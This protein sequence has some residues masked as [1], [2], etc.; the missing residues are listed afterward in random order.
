MALLFCDSFNHVEDGYELLKWDAYYGA[1]YIEY[2]ST[3]GRQGDYGM[4]TSG[5]TSAY[6]QKTLSSNKTT[7]ITGFA[8]KYTSGSSVNQ[9]LMFLEGASAQF[10]V[11]VDINGAIH[12]YKGSSVLLGSSS[13][14]VVSANTW[15]YFEIKI[16]FS[17]TVGTVE[18]KIDGTQVIN[19]TGIDTC[20]TANAYCTAVQLYG[21]GSYCYFD[22]F[23][24]CDTLG[25]N[26]NDFLGDVEITPLYPTSDV[27]NDFTPSAGV[28]HYAL[29]DDPQ[30]ANDTDHNESS[31]IGNKDTYGVT[32]F[33]G[34]GTVLGVQV[35]A[36]VRNTDIGTM[37]VRTITKSGTVLTENEGSDF[38]LSQT[39]KGAMTIHEQEPT[40][41]VAWT[42]A[43]I[44]AAEFGLKV[45]S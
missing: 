16:L 13:N 6:L 29:V 9:F 34:T 23:Y 38:T 41:S 20:A 5:S 37:K 43:K 39:M 42:A 28:N 1:A 21:N 15:A 44:N 24:V 4:R 2:L 25:S 19:L 8:L 22:D 17:Q 27:E 12:V 35:C 40:D 45:Q 31:T 33:S 26:N 32:T 18:V 10:E 14:G 7:I 30:L 11:R 36:A 3:A